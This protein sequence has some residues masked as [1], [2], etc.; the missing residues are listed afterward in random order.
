MAMAGFDVDDIEAVFRV[1]DILKERKQ[2]S[3]VDRPHDLSRATEAVYRKLVRLTNLIE[4]TDPTVMTF[5]EAVENAQIIVD[6]VKEA[7]KTRNR[8]PPTTR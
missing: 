8:K 3:P 6:A 7:N 1:V 4:Y 5:E 2:F